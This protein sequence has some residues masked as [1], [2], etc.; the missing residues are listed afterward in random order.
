MYFLWR[1]PSIRWSFTR[2]SF[3]NAPFVKF[4]H[5]FPPSKFCA[6]WY[7]VSI[8]TLHH[9]FHQLTIDGYF[10]VHSSSVC[11]SHGLFLWPVW[12]QRGCGCS[13]IGPGTGWQVANWL[14]MSS[15][16]DSDV[17]NRFS[18][19]FVGFTLGMAYFAVYV[20]DKNFVKLYPTLHHPTLLPYIGT[21]VISTVPV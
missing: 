20:N 2:Q 8:F 5:T 10:T 21:F 15:K 12:R 14:K 4:R 3:G 7:T 19:I 6:I 17:R 11:I 13:L 16:V 9:Q 1:L 18:S